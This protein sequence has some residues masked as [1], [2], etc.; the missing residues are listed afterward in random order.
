MQAQD[1]QMLVMQQETR[2]NIDN[3]GSQIQRLGTSQ[4]SLLGQQHSVV[5]AQ[6]RAA[7][8]DIQQGHGHIATL[9]GSIHSQTQQLAALSQDTQVYHSQI[10]S[11]I[12]EAYQHTQQGMQLLSRQ[13]DLILH[14]VS[15][16][17]E[18]G[19]IRPDEKEDVL[20]LL[21]QL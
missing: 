15:K 5:L 20:F 14:A 6:I 10:G 2:A 11:R 7:R 3:L 1:R 9:S 4:E 16:P 19:L 12:E 18:T 21:F 13:S 8:D 17:R